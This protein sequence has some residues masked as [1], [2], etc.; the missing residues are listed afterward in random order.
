MAANETGSLVFINDVT[1]DKSNEMNSAV[2]RVMLSAQ[3]QPNWPTL[4]SADGQ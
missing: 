1:T 2:Y 3:I 4:H